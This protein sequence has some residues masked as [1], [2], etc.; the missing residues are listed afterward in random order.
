MAVAKFR[1]YDI[2]LSD[3]PDKK[4]YSLVNN[5]KVYFGGDPLRYQHY[6][7]KIGYYKYLDHHDEKRRKQFQARF[8]HCKDVVGSPCFFSYYLLW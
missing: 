5:K 8:K 4:Y 3:R 6:E 1:N 7:D 2:Y